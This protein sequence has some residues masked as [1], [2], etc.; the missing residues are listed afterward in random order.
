M[1]NANPR[2][3]P[4]L[5]ALLAKQ[6]SPD[7]HMQAA[8]G[9]LPVNRFYPDPRARSNARAAA[10]VEVCN[11]CPV[12]SSCRAVALTRDEHGVW[13]G[14]AEADRTRMRT[15]LTDGAPVDAVLAETVPLDDNEEVTAA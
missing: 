15:A 7:W 2:Q 10:A 8:C 3:A 12:R 11:A 5:F 13:G 14:T 6:I 4:D 1:S 9:D